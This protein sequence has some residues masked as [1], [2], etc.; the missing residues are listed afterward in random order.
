DAGVPSLR[1]LPSE[2]F[3]LLGEAVTS[4]SDRTVTVTAAS[5]KASISRDVTFKGQRDDSYSHAIPPSFDPVFQNGDNVRFSYDL[6]GLRGADGGI[7]IVSDID[8]AVP[9]AFPDNNLDA[10]GKKYRLNGLAGTI[11]LHA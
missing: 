4:R 10:H 8:R 1:L 11:T 6:R 9:Q 7:L 2:I 5:G 3:D